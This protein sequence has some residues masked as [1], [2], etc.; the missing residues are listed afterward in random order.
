MAKANLGGANITWIQPLGEG[1]V[2]SAF[3]SSYGDGAM[4]LVHRFETNDALQAEIN[5]LSRSG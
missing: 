3:H 5:R 4:S 2:F 1:S